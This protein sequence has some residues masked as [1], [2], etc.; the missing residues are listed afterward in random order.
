MAV[1]N[2]VARINSEGNMRPVSKI[3]SDL[4]KSVSSSVVQFVITLVTTP[5]MTRL[6]APDSYATFGIINSAA[7]LTIGIGLLSLPH[8]YLV[9][10]DR[11]ARH[12]ILQMMVMLVAGLA[13]LA[14]AAA[15]L[16]AMDSRFH[17]G[18]AALVL[19]PILVL[20]CGIRQIMLIIATAR[21]NFDSLS[22]GQVV[23]PACS[24]GGSI[25]LGAVFGSHPVFILASVAVGHMATASI[26]TVM[27]LRDRLHGLR[28]LLRSGARPFHILHHHSD[29]VVYSTASAQ[30]QPLVMLGIQIAIAT[31]FSHQMAGHYIL[32]VSI[33]TLPVSLIALTTAPVVYRH[34]IEIERTAPALLVR[35]VVR[36]MLF[37][38]AAGVLLLSPVFFFGRPIFAIA[39]GQVW[40]PAGT[41]AATLSIA[42]VGSFAAVGVQSIF[43]VTKRLKTQFALEAITCALALGAAGLSFKTMDFQTA[44]FYLSA[45]WFLRNVVLLVACVAVA[46]RHS[47][48]ATEGVP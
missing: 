28:V 4:S 13:A 43:N 17:T 26:I 14:A 25:A 10:K 45:I 12:A 31:F 36:A 42:Y 6:Y 19:L 11:T 30:A 21:A 5:L 23:E 9:E 24:R 1:A 8:A 46:S 37:Y 39:F 16:L 27:A 34:F 38:L 48:H 20:T 40:E 15:M 44:M 33:L 18:T 29:F 2:S 22:L 41:I 7:A 35:H 47:R 3:F 32:A